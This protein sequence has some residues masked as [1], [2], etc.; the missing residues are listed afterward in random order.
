M[1][2]M[3]KQTILSLNCSEAL[4]LK[5][6]QNLLLGLILT[7]S[8]IYMLSQTDRLSYLVGHHVEQRAGLSEVVDGF[9]QIS[10]GLPLLQCLRKLPD[11]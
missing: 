5:M 3:T 8:M 11:P 10:K 1:H 7:V 4:K 2:L 6:C 9:L